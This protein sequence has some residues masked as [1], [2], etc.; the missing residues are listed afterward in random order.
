MTEEQ[1]LRFFDDAPGAHL[2]P[3]I[4][5]T[6]TKLRAIDHN[7][8]D[9]TYSRHNLDAVNFTTQAKMQQAFWPIAYVGSEKILW[10][11]G[12][13]SPIQYQFQ[14]VENRLYDITVVA[15]EQDAF[16]FHNELRLSTIPGTEDIVHHIALVAEADFGEKLSPYGF[17]SYCVLDPE[18]F[19]PTY[20]IF[21]N[22]NSKWAR[23]TKLEEAEA[24]IM[25]MSE[26]IE[27]LKRENEEL[28]EKLNQVC[29]DDNAT[30][31]LEEVNNG[32]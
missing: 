18:D 4:L 25:F 20:T 17:D 29:S 27:S 2:N 26:Q 28:R 24:Q 31:G 11:R 23:K 19:A 12:L 5:K 1:L 8:T 14:D 10:I 22:E 3:F 32:G 30:N 7:K 21:D 15:N 6:L 9:N 13:R 16:L